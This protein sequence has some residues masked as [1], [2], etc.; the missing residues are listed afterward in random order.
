MGELIGFIIG[1]LFLCIIIDMM[2]MGQLGLT[3]GFIGLLM[4]ILI[5]VFQA[6]IQV[7]MQLIGVFVPILVQITGNVLKYTA[8]G[9]GWTLNQGFK[10][11]NRLLFAKKL[12]ILGPGESLKPGVSSNE[13]YD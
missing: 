12:L 1:I 10:G 6:V 13:L 7:A 8:K 11:G 9:L 2:F 4:Q 3:G 5:S